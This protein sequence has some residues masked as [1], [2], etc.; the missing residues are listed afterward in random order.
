MLFLLTNCVQMYLLLVLT[1]QEA[2]AQQLQF[3]IILLDHVRS[4]HL[5]RE[6]GNVSLFVLL[7]CSVNVGSG[8]CGLTGE[9][10]GSE[11]QE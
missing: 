5:S 8:G 9:G 4:I 2:S 1:D 3:A 10:K 7:F 6:V 11:E